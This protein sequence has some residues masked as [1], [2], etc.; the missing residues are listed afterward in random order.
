M[1]HSWGPQERRRQE[2]QKQQAH[3]QQV[4]GPPGRVTKLW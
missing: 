3:L 4:A 2:L 1:V